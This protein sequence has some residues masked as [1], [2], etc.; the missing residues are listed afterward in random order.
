M[1]GAGPSPIMPGG[2]VARRPLHLVVMAD[3]SGGMAGQKMQ[4]LNYAVA[5]MLPQLVEWEDEQLQARVLVRVLGFATEPRWHVAEPTPVAALRWKPL[6][7]VEHGWT[8]MGPAFRTVAEVLSPGR[9]E[10]QALRP[11]ILLVTDGLPTDPPGGFDAGLDALL[12]QPA[13][14]AALRLAIAIGARASSPYLERFIGD[15]AVPVLVADRTD[16]IADRL[17]VA[18]IAMTRMSEGGADRA[19]LA[20]QLLGAP[21][22]P[23]EGEET[24]V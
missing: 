6:H 9:L 4:A 17:I 1:N 20:G 11:A 18:S 14:R 19:I 2:G 3:C 24:I 16:E 8:N 22:R 5:A 10:R 23:A 15:P 12:A 7:A 21:A 13:G